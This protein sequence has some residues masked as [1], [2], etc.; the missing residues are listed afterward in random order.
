MVLG[1]ALRYIGFTRTRENVRKE[2]T[3]MIKYFTYKNKGP[4]GGYLILQ[5]LQIAATVGVAILL[6][7]I[8]DRL[9]WRIEQ[10]QLAGL[11]ADF[12]VC[13]GY[14]ALLGILILQSNLYAECHD[15]P[16]GR[17]VGRFFIHE[18]GRFPEKEF[19][20]VPLSDES[21]CG[22]GRGELF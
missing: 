10:K 17:P 2:G 14:A 6:N 22:A 18:N 7:W 16:S 1:T 4:F 3:S 12:A 15:A 9:L 20:P 11:W 19:G 5:V 8:I 13:A 21:E